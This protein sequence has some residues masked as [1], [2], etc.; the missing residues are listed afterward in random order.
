LFFVLALH[1]GHLRAILAVEKVDLET[2]N[3][4]LWEVAPVT[5]WSRAR[6]ATKYSYWEM[7]FAA[8]AHVITL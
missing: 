8:V 7:W 2:F 1:S 5:G 4:L 6:F 3:A